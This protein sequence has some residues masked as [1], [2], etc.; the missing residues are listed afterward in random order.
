MAAST[1]ADVAFL[2]IPDVQGNS[3]QISRTGWFE[4]IEHTIELAPPLQSSDKKSA[5]NACTASVDT[6][7]HP[8]TPTVATLLGAPAGDVRIEV[9]VNEGT[10]SRAILRG[11][12]ITQLVTRL[13]N[14]G[15]MLERL[16]IRF[17][18]IDLEQRSQNPDG[19]LR[20]P[21]TGSFVCAPAP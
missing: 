4:I 3:Q 21:V 6:R 1:S 7:L 16:T 2:Q 15:E 10:I 9:D 5:F 18:R 8:A 12:V 20:P 19:T 17:D 11:A 14:G 13:A